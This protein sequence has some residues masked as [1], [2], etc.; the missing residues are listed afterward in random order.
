M[1]GEFQ[2]PGDVP[3]VNLTLRCLTSGKEVGPIIGKGGEIIHNIREES[4]AKIH[5]SDGSVPERVITVTGT[6]HAIFKAYSLICSK[7]EDEEGGKKKEGLTLRLLVAAS[8]CG[9]LIGKGGSKVKEIR[10]ISGASVQVASDTL[11]GC[12]ER[13]VTVSGEKENITQCI[14]HICCVMLESPAKGSTVQ[15]QPGRG[16]MRADG[17]EGRAGGG[18]GAAH[19][20]A[21]LLGLGGGGAGALAA[22]ASLAHSQIHETRRDRD[23]RG[24]RSVETSYQMSVA[25]EVIGSVIGKG[26]SKIAEIRQMSGA[27][28]RI[29]KS[30]DPNASPSTERQIMISG[31]ADSVALAKSLINMSLDLH[32]AS[33]ERS[34]SSDDEEGSD[35]GGTP[36]RSRVSRV[37]RDDRQTREH[38]PRYY[39]DSPLA[40][41]GGGDGL[42]GLANLL[43][44]PDVLAAVNI[45]GQLSSMG[46][47]SSGA[48]VN[49][50]GGGYRGGRGSYS[51][52]STRGGSR[53][54]SERHR[55]N[56]RNKFAPY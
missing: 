33:L 17:R 10:E 14:Y 56:K 23:E 46:G 34:K 54:D 4:G 27:M 19:A 53:E 52:G 25:N 45:L 16:G 40:G 28:I 12:T 2:L 24:E 49:Q 5:I 22:M 55:D 31:S 6:T 26:G 15:Y 51:G 32:K 44:K 39:S 47:G 9:S 41:G 3:S 7:M 1:S 13:C 29:S 43:T 18:G 11:P 42:T 20:L 30:E 35:S 36:V 48:M 50:M 37:S 21:G 8:Q 38:V